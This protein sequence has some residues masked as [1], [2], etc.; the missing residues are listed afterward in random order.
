M[1]IQEKNVREFW[2]EI[3]EN[4]SSLSQAPVNPRIGELERMIKRTKTKRVW[5][6][7]NM[8]LF[9]AIGGYCVYEY[10]TYEEQLEPA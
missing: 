4:E 9:A 6:N 8:L 5:L 3:F 7:F 2:M 10:L 1:R